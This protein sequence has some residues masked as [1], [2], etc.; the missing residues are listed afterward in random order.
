MQWFEDLA[1]TASLIAERLSPGGSFLA[2]IFGPEG[3]QELHSGLAAVNPDAVSLP[4]DAFPD[5]A[6]LQAIF[7]PHFAQVEIVEWRF[8]R[9]YPI[10]ADLLRHIRRTGTGGLRQG[11]ALLDRPRVAAL[12]KWFLKEYGECRVTYQVFLIHCTQGELKR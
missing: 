8:R 1:R 11:T 4:S 7:S 10:L 2:T 12:E 3:L 6:R 5:Q 9:S